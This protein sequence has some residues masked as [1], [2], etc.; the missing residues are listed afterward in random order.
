MSTLKRNNIAAHAADGARIS[1]S[2]MKSV[3]HRSGNAPS[4][5]PVLGLIALHVGLKRRLLQ[6][7][8]NGGPGV[9]TTILVRGSQNMAPPTDPRIATCARAF[10]I[11]TLGLHHS[12]RS[13]C[14]T[15]G[16]G[17]KPSMRRSRK[18]AGLGTNSHLVGC[19]TRCRGRIVAPVKGR[20]WN[21]RVPA[22]GDPPASGRPCG[23]SGKHRRGGIMAL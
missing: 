17:L 23:L 15:S 11:W 6:L 10:P 7:I 12:T 21:S 16:A 19:S 20:L 4:R 13:P 18:L 1:K 3:A 22:N 9:R 5:L 14:R 8:S 2:L